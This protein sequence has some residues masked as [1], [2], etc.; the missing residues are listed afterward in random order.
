VNIVS[1][2]SRLRTFTAA[3]HN[4]SFGGLA[5]LAPEKID[6]NREIAFNLDIPLL[7]KP[8]SG[9]GNIRYLNHASQNHP[10]LFALGVQFTQINQDALL[11]LIKR[12]H[13][14]KVAVRRQR[15]RLAQTDFLPY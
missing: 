13:S 14:K 7:G 9:K 12:I 8:L 15:Y 5:M 11:Y 3:L 2:E 10:G 6:I 4:L 1:E